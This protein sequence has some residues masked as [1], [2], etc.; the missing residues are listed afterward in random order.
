MHGISPELLITLLGIPNIEIEK[1]SLNDGKRELSI[2]VKSTINGTDCPKCGQRLHKQCHS[3]HEIKLR[4]LSIFGYVTYIIIT[5]LRYECEHCDGHPTTT[6]ALNW[7][8]QRHTCTNA[9]EDYILLSLINST[10]QDISI[11]ENIGYDVIE[12]ILNR[13]V[14]TN[15]DWDTIEK[16]DIIGIDEISIKKGHRDFVVI[17]TAFINEQLRILAVLENREK[18]TIKKFFKSIPK[19][20]RKSVKAICS[21][22]YIGFINAAKEVFGRKI[23][24]IA[25]RFHVTKLYRESIDTIRK[26]EMKRLK[27]ELSEQEY[28]RLNNV[29]WILRKSPEELT[30]EELK[31]LKLLFKYS[32]DIKLVYELSCD[33][34]NIFDMN[35]NQGM[36]KRRIKGWIRRVQNSGLTC[37]NTFIKTLSARMQEITNYFVD[38]FNS[39]FVE[40]INNKIKVIKRRCYGI[41]NIRNL[42]QRIRL[43][44]EWRELLSI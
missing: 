12:G 15:I 37:F 13:N 25:D 17:V 39:G 28:K 2:L 32:P 1:V 8:E 16:I 41:T 5:P 4:H 31:V 35:I 10:I 43:D 27:K 20:L 9:Y 42:F 40:G 3:N 21:D 24:I 30:D 36:A 6:Q 22:L 38:R 19:R 44:L 34:T 33:L 29:M 18:A 7:Y 11:K 14:S 26:K 23:R